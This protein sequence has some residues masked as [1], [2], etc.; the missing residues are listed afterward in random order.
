MLLRSMHMS[1]LHQVPVSRVQP[2]CEVTGSARASGMSYHMDFENEGNVSEEDA[3]M[4]YEGGFKLV[5]DTKSLLYL[6][7]M[8]VAPRALALCSPRREAVCLP[9][10]TPGPKS[11]Q[12]M[13]NDW[14]CGCCVQLDWSA[15]LVGGGFQF[16]NPNAS[17][18]CG[19]GKSFGV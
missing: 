2:V 15:A 19:C 1:C 10:A 9:P 17:A 18:S 16:R 6:F 13:W 5:C 12:G 7:G 14:G 8:E 11:A 4:E 3:V